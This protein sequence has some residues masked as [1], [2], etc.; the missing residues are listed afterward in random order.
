MS[1][2]SYLFVFGRTPVL[3]FAELH[4]FFPEITLLAPEVAKLTIPDELDVHVWISRLGGT[5]KIAEYCEVVDSYDAEILTQLLSGAPNQV[6]FGVS[7]YGGVILSKSLL[8]SMKQ[9]LEED[10]KVVRYVTS[11]E[12]QQLS[13][14]V[15][16]KKQVHE[17]LVIQVEKSYVL[18]RTLAV[19]EYESWNTR[20]WNRPHA[21]AKSG[22][23]P[24]KVARM[25][26][27][28]AFAKPE[29]EVQ[30]KQQTLYDPFC[31]MGTVLSEGYMMGIRVIGSDVVPDVI[32]KAKDNLAWTVKQYPNP[33]GA[34]AKI[35]VTDAVHAADSVAPNSIHAIVTEPFMGSTSIVNQQI[36]DAGKVKN[37][38]K[39][40]EKLYIGCLKNWHTL[41]VQNGK[42][43][44]A[45][46]SYKIGGRTYF[47]KKVVDMCENLGYTIE[48]GPIEYS[49][50]NAV[51]HRNFYIL[52]KK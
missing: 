32:R 5:V 7:G 11:H 41:L 48:D 39:G 42:I 50:P 9:R 45:F 31:G 52:R 46:P 25:I 23:L 10:G 3:A 15:L 33:R 21:D 35:F 12:G 6:T 18:G 4:A 44:M 34:V 22:M 28:I 29:A 43:V 47:V 38:V 51:V 24:L 27:N 20:D 37:I 40:L 30:E 8:P 17:L 19:Q 16:D 26:V 36:H 1:A 14:V 49:R 13:S 2:H